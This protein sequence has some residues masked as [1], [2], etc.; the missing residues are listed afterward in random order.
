M[1]RV[2]LRGLEFIG[3]SANVPIIDKPGTGTTARPR[4]VGLLERLTKR[5]KS[6]NADD[7]THQVKQRDMK[8]MR[9][10]KQVPSLPK[11]AS[12]E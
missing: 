2:P 1:R 6:A 11:A 3:E 8:S 4:L 10:S 5:G 12:Q 9:R 7:A